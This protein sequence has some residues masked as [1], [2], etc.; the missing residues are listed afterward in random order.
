VE[1]SF[2]RVIASDKKRITRTR[3]RAMEFWSAFAAERANL[4]LDVTAKMTKLSI[5]LR[6]PKTSIPLRTMTTSSITFTKMMEIWMLSVTTK[7]R[8]SH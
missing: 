8:K 3:I 7:F 2:V 6:R 1:D 5:G 4:H